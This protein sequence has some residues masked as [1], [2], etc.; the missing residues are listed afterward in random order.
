M[1]RQRSSSAILLVDD[2]PNDV[3]LTQLA[4]KRAGVT[5]PLFTV[6]D[7]CEAIAYLSGADQYRDR[8]TFPDPALIL[9]DLKMPRLDGFGVLEW[10]QKQKCFDRIVRIV[11]TS[12]NI[13]SDI[14]RAW[15]LGADDYFV[16]PNEHTELIRILQ[17]L[18]SQWLLASGFDD[19]RLRQRL[20]PAWFHP[21]TDG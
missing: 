8:E 2:Q 14:A 7:G 16:K 3:L 5:N 13:D 21:L 10:L 4:L 6:G 12:S 20:S 11:L 18:N 19:C 1:V 17:K 15:S 9:L